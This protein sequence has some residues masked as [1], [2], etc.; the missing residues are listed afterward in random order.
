MTR[1]QR[2]KWVMARAAVHGRG[3]VQELRMWI[4]WRN[5]HPWPLVRAVCRFAPGS[6]Q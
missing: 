3:G 4:I 1:R 5:E 6:R 2:Q